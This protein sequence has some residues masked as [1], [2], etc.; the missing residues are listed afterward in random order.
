ML[1]ATSFKN[2]SKPDGIEGKHQ[3]SLS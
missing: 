1:M 2:Q 3:K